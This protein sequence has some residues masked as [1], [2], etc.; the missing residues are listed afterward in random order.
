MT[1]L[2]TFIADAKKGKINIVEH[3]KKALQYAQE[4]NK[5]YHYITAWADVEAQAENLQKKI[6]EGNAKGRLFGVIISVK[7]DM[8]VKDVETTASSAILK[9]YKPVFNATAVQRC[10]DEDAIILGKTVQD[11]FGFGTFGDK[12]GKGFEKPKH[13]LDTKR[14]PGGSSSG[15]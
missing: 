1:E 2:A 8:C 9:D 12:P 13:P 11:E 7:D 6:Q 3:A 10:R 5:E 14:A 4:I 15:A